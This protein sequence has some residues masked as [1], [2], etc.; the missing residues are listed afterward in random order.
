M[1]V[2]LELELGEEDASV[3]D[4]LTLHRSALSPCHLEGSQWVMTGPVS[5]TAELGRHMTST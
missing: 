3:W 2:G 1:G 5:L 4:L